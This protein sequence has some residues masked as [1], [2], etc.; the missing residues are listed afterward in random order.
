MG[1]APAHRWLHQDITALSE[2]GLCSNI[3][4]KTCLG[5]CP[6]YFLYQQTTADKH[7]LLLSGCH[8]GWK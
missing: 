1:P 4:N 7:Q 5:Y 8:R 2:K 3:A 6:E